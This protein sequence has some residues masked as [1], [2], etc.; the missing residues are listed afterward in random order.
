VSLDWV[1][2]EDVMAEDY[3]SIDTNFETGTTIDVMKSSLN[4]QQAC[5]RE[6]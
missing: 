1:T 5:S 6:R 2:T 4:T 3:F